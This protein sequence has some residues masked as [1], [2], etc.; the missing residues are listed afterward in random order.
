MSSTDVMFDEFDATKREKLIVYLLGAIQFVHILDF[1]ILMPLGPM[2]MR[3]F[4]VTTSQFGLLVSS[5]T[6]A[7]GISNFLASIIADR[8]ERKRIL[9]VCFIGFLIGTGLCAFAPNF[10]LLLG[11]RIFAGV[12]GGVLNAV[13]FALIPDLI[14]PKRRGTANG[15]VMS[16][17]SVS[18][19]IGVPIGLALAEMFSWHAPFLFIV[20]IGLIAFVLATLILPLIHNKSPA[21]S[22]VDTLKTFYHI[23]T[24]AIHI[25]GFLLTSFL[26]F[27]IFMI[28]P[29][30]SPSMVKN[31]GLAESDLKYIYLFGGTA[32][33]FSARWIGR[34][35]DRLGS[36]RVMTWVAFLSFIPL[37]LITHLGVTPLALTLVVTTT[38][39]M[40]GSGR[41]IPAMTL[42]SLVVDP[43]KRGTFMGL[44]NAFRQLSSGVASL[45]AGLII[46]EGANGTLERFNLLGYAAVTVTF[47][48][49]LMARRISKKSGI[50]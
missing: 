20:A 46:Y 40:T 12:F 27:G 4:N 39:M 15:I 38:F 19:V 24:E 8:F 45:V 36:F 41:F 33:V 16:A 28:V 9:Q 50:Q 25:E 6:F 49:W 3:T 21:K 44:E 35:C 43:K 23:A 31:V 13:V 5:Y 17:F 32:T 1:V 29:F 18:S 26:A 34:L 47:M 10:E 42:L 48:A 7:A 2:L 14:P 37:I 11:A 30:I 22:P